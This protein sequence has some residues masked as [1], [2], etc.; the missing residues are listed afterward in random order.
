MVDMAIEKAMERLPAVITEE[1]NHR[2]V[3]QYF[4]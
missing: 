1:D 3:D 4:T 2:L